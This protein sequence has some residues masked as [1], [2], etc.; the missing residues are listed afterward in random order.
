MILRY[1]SQVRACY[2]EGLK[3][4]QALL[5]QVTMAFVVGGQGQ[6]N[7]ANVQRS[8]LNDRPV[9]DCIQMKMLSWKFPQPRGGKPVPVSYPFML[10]PVKS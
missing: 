10:R 4:N 8:S 7:S 2:E 1:L 9:E 6:V 3:R 5:G